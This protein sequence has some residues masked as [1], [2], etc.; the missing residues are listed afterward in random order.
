MRFTHRVFAVLPDL[1]DMGGNRVA[2]KVTEAGGRAAFVHID[3]SN[4]PDTD[5]LVRFAL[6][7]VG[8]FGGAVNNAGVGQPVP[9]IHELARRG[10]VKCGVADPR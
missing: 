9:K 2:G 5:A 1:D 10:R 3:V 7:H 6:D 4:E 8:R